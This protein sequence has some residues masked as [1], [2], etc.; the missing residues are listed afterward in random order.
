MSLVGPKASNPT[1]T[2]EFNTRVSASAYS[3]ARDEVLM[4]KG[5]KFL[6]EDET[7]R[8]MKVEAT[9]SSVKNTIEEISGVEKVT[10]EQKPVT[11]YRHRF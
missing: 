4:T 2:I 7:A 3:R 8:T 1:L 11:G 9:N 10:S 5:A 6:S